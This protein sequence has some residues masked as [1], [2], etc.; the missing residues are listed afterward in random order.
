MIWI[1]IL[2]ILGGIIVVVIVVIYI[3]N[4]KATTERTAYLAHSQQTMDRYCCGV[5]MSLVIPNGERGIMAQGYYLCYICKMQV[6]FEN[7]LGSDCAEGD[8][9]D[10]NA[11]VVPF[12]TTTSGIGGKFK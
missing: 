9:I 8:W 11:P 1:G 10:P 2:G 12:G 7:A 4:R 6:E 3:K 5:K